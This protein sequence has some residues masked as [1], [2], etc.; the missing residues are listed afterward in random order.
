[1]RILVATLLLVLS[2]GTVAG[3]WARAPEEWVCGCRSGTKLASDSLSGGSSY[4]EVAGSFINATAGTLNGI[5]VTGGPFGSTSPGVD[6][7]SL[8]IWDNNGPC[9]VGSGLFYHT[10]LAPTSQVSAGTDPVDGFPLFTYTF[11]LTVNPNSG[12]NFAANHLYW[13]TVVLATTTS[14]PDWG[15]KLVS[16]PA[17]P[18]AAQFRSVSWGYPSWVPESTVLDIK[19]VDMQFELA[20]VAT[21]E[22]TWGRVRSLYR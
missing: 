22:T 4:A 2:A 3:S 6:Y 20:P 17:P 10:Y 5:S 8:T 1:M 15:V 9:T 18:C 11:D 7:W 14:S 13:C 12:F 21:Q 16:S 19:G